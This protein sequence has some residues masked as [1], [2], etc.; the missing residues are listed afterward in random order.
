MREEIDLFRLT[1]IP[2][3]APENRIVAAKT[4]DA[5]QDDS[6]MPFG[7]YKGQS[8]ESVPTYLFWLWSNGKDKDTRCPVA[9]YIRRNKAALEKEYPDGIW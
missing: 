8:M 5:L 7:K 4:F 3:C 9:D 2:W 6:P 1:N